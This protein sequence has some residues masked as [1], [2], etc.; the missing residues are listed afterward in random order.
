MGTIEKITEE[1]ANDLHAAIVKHGVGFVNGDIP[2][3]PASK[4]A[5]VNALLYG[6]PLLSHDNNG[7]IN[8]FNYEAAKIF[9]K[10]IEQMLGMPSV[11]LAPNVDNIRPNRKTYLDQSLL[12]CVTLQDARR[13]QWQPDGSTREILIDAEVFPYEHKGRVSNVASIR[14]KGYYQS[15]VANHS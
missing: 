10:T 6:T 3:N 15:K 11:E 8:F 1:L 14:F 2:E 4:Y 9:G 7:I 12:G 13:L 5:S